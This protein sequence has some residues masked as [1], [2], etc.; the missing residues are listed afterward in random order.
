[1]SVEK[2]HVQAH[3]FSLKTFRVL[4]RWYMSRLSSISHVWGDRNSSHLSPDYL[5][6]P[7]ADRIRLDDADCDRIFFIEA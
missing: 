1:M 3:N 7:L 2:Q 6:N 4:Y 5:A